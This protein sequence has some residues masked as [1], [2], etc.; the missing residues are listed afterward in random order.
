MSG[1][2][3]AYVAVE[4]VRYPEIKSLDGYWKMR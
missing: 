4:D 2:D 1:I 3:K